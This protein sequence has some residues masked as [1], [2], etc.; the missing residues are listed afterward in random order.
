MDDKLLD[1]TAELMTEIG[2][3][4]ITLQAV[5]ERAKVSRATLWRQAGGKE[6]LRAGLTR[7]LTVDYRASMW[8]VL[9][10]PGSAQERL[11]QALD[12]LCR[13]VERHLP[14]LSAFE[15]T[16]HDAEDDDPDVVNY[17]DPLIRLIRDG[18]ADGTLAPPTDCD[19]AG[20]LAFNSVCWP[21]VHLRRHHD[22]P[23]DEARRLLVD[24]VVAGM[25]GGQR[26]RRPSSLPTF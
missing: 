25:S 26:G 11:R 15:T 14:L 24:L 3:D 20:S 16:F 18:M 1:A 17:S 6:A 23:P 21:Y 4:R 10:A 22:W 7:R 5:A 9:T 19:R 12:T 2:W 13:V 8:S